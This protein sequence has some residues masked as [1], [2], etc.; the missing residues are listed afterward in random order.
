MYTEGG[1]PTSVE[2]PG[3]LSSAV[4]LETMLLVVMTESGL[5]SS[6]WRGRPMLLLP[7]EDEVEEEPGPPWTEAW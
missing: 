5:R 7:E 1:I 4:S 6:C 3:W 2:S